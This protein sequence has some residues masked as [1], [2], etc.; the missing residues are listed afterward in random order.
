MTDPRFGNDLL[1]AIRLLPFGSGV[2]FRHYHQGPVERRKLFRQV[3]TV[4]RQ[5]G[6]MLILAGSEADA[7]RW[8]ADGFHLRAGVS[9][10]SLPRSAPVHNR[11]ELREALHNGAG[12]LFI[13]PLFPTASHPD[14][15]ALGRPAFNALAKQAGNAAVIA[16]G[17]MAR[18]RA[19]NPRLAHGWA[20]IDA[21][22]KN[23]S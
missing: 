9:R 3:L 1:P 7:L 20:A 18:R 19:L 15:K 11:A 10:S 12:L 5:R 17:G 13:S 14:G 16:L 6:H 23:P 22:R 4:C 8:R 21:F 2:V